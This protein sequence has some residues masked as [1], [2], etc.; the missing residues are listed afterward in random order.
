MKRILLSLGLILGLAA[1]AFSQA[2]L[3]GPGGGGGASQN[4]AASGAGGNGGVGCAFV[5]AFF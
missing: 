1:P 5:Q 2:M 3:G 4:G